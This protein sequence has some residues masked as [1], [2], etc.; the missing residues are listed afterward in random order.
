MRGKSII[1][2]E[3]NRKKFVTSVSLSVFIVAT[4]F[5]F[6]PFTIYKGNISEFII[7]LTTILTVFLFPA[8]IIASILCAIG[9]LLPK[10]LHRRYISILFISGLLIWMQGNILM[11]DYG[12][13][14]KGGIDWT[15]STWRGWL[16]GTLWIM[17]L[18]VA[19]LFYKQIYRI[20]TFVIIILFSLQL[21]FLIFV[22]VQNL[23]F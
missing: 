2:Q 11:W 14:G 7:P 1:L 9:L 18:I 8:L 10:E 19:F 15:I 21:M 3:A 23:S 16:D 4:I 6:L 12:L 22:K 5:L 17:F 20:A 13:L